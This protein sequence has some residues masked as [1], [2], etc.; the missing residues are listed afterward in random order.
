MTDEF[1]VVRKLAQIEIY[2]EELRTLTPPEEIHQSILKQRFVTF[3]LH[4]AIQAAIDVAAHIVADQKLG[5]PNGY[6]GYF[7]MLGSR[8]W[9]E[10][11]L[12]ERLAH[13]AGFRNI[14]VH[15]YEDVDLGRV[16]EILRDHLGD[17]LAFVAAIR[18]KL[19]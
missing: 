4:L 12:A 10:R 3:T 8:G 2:V 11:N 6:R 9:I 16:E 5:L 7:L 13:M 14:V 15:Q 17:L 1:L 19:S 18:Q